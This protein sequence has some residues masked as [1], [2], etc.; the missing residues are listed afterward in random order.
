ML[1]GLID[2]RRSFVREVNEMFWFV[3]RVLLCINEV[4]LVEFFELCGEIGKRDVLRVGNLSW[5]KGVGER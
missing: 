1:K 3:M 2:R 4:F 5:G